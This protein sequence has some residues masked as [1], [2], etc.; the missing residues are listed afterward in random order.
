VAPQVFGTS[1]STTF[2][3]VD[4][5]GARINLP[6]GSTHPQGLAEVVVGGGFEMGSRSTA[7][8]I[9]RSSSTR[10]GRSWTAT[11]SC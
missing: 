5:D 2:L 3:G 4:P 8:A 1:A 7:T 9:A 11:P 6:F 10:P